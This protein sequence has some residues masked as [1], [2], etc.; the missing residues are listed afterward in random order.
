MKKFL[1]F[2][3]SFLPAYM[4]ASGWDGQTI[5]SSYAGGDGTE[6]SPYLISTAEELAK[7]AADLNADPSCTK[8]VFYRMTTDIT[9]NDSVFTRIVPTTRP[10]EYADYPADS[11][12]FKRTP[13]IGGHVKD[14]VST[15]FEGSFDGGGH[16]ISGLYVWDQSITYV[17]LFSMC[18]GASIR[19]LRITDSYF[20]TNAQFGVLAGQVIDSELLNCAVDSCYS[21]GGGS[22]GGLLA[23]T[24]E[25]TTTMQNCYAEGWVFGKND[26]G[27]LVG[28]IG[29]RDGNSC[30]VN[31]CFSYVYL[32]VKRR[33]NGSLAFDIHADAKVDDCYWIA[34]QEAKQPVW[35]GAE[36]LGENIRQLTAEEFSS[37]DLVNELNR[38]AEGIDDAYLWQMGEK[39]PVLAQPTAISIESIASD[40]VSASYT[41]YNLYGLRV[42]SDCRGMT[43]SHGRKMMR[44]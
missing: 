32:R 10:N 15:Y 26:M 23:G 38:V 16:T 5:A 29:V 20:L 21:E 27:G 31:N 28:R 37:E 35:N 4:M 41:S 40:A 25:G 36:L 2:A 33:N 14:G 11:S 19:N 8:G 24:L 9:F 42:S 43:I 17:G 6:E 3:L 30:V 34:L 7:L 22:K 13:I 18:K 12:V 1:L 39:H 44:R